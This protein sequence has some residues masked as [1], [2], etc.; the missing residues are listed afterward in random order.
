MNSPL[1]PLSCKRGE[2]GTPKE[3]DEFRQKFLENNKCNNIEENPLLLKEETDESVPGFMDGNDMIPTLK[4]GV[5]P[6]CNSRTIHHRNNPPIHWWEYDTTTPDPNNRFNGLIM[7]TPDIS[8]Q[9]DKSVRV[10]GAGCTRIPMMNHGAI[11]NRDPLN[12][13]CRNNPPIHWWDTDAPTLPPINR[14]NGFKDKG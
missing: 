7:K 13:A 3:K 9:T 8:W 12:N 6:T 2:I 10:V 1:N 4:R 14:F 11:P 5:N